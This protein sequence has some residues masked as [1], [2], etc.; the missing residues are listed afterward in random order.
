MMESGHELA[1]WSDVLVVCTPEKDFVELLESSYNKT[2]ID[3]VRLPAGIN[4]SNQ[5]LGINWATADSDLHLM[6]TDANALI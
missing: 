5:Y 3:L 1:E 4:P 2:I 6:L